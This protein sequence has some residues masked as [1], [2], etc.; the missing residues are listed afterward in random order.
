MNSDEFRRAAGITAE[1][2]QKWFTP[3]TAAMAEFGID[4]PRRQAAFIAQTAHESQGYSVLAES[5]YYTDPKRIAI[6]F[7]TGFDLDHDGLVDPEEIEFAKGYARN[8]QKLANRAYANRSGNGPESSGDGYRY[9]GRGLIQITFKD[10]YRE[11]GKA[12]ALDLLSTPE[13]LTDPLQAARSAAWFWQRWGIN[14]PAD[15]SD[16]IAVTRKINPALVGLT[17]RVARYQVA[18]GVLCPSKS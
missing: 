7:K 14:A 18:V 10:N 3:I 12:L 9:R 11:C 4:T 15:K 6:L 1:L 17:D 5:L 2:A 13:L 8:S 16:M